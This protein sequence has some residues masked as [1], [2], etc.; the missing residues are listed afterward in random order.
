MKYRTHNCNELSLVHEGQIVKLAGW[1]HR[2][3]DHGGILFI[4]LRDKFGITQIVCSSKDAPELHKVMDSLRSEWVIAIEGRVRKR[5]EGMSNPNLSTGE[6]EVEV[7]GLT[8]LSKS[9]VPPFS[10]C[11]D[12]VNVNEELRL[13]YRYLDMRRGDILSKLSLRHQLMMA[14][15]KY[16]DKKG[17]TEVVTPVL[18]K[19]TPE[20]ARD[21]VVPSR[22]HPGDFYALPQSPQIFKQL[23]MIGGL[24]KYF[25]IATCFRDEDLRADRQPEFSQIDMEM[26]FATQEDLFLLVEGLVKEL[27]LAGGVEIHGALPRMT[28][29][30]AIDEYGTDKPD[31]RFGMKLKDCRAYANQFTFSIFL[32]QLA[33]GGT[34][35]GF[36]VEGGADISRKQID[37]YTEFVKRYGSQGLVWI[38]KINGEI[39][40]NV[41]KFASKEVFETLLS[42]LE[43]E[44]GDAAFLIA[45]S[46]KIVN[47]S[48]DHLRRL[49]AKER[50]LCDPGQYAFIWVTD[51]PLFAEEDGKIVSEH[52]PFT[53]PHE[54]DIEFLETDPLKVRSSGY[55]LVLNGYEIASGSQRIHCSD[56]QQQVFRVL[57]L[58]LE[59]IKNKFG[60]FTEALRFGTPPHLG[61]ALGLDRIV[62]ILGKAEGIREVIAFPKTQK[63]TDLMM[64]APSE[65]G[66]EQMKE[67][68][69]RVNPS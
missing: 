60:F 2:F 56:L 24:D 11:D 53:S 49:I 15:R 66:L 7:Q 37:G 22:V 63:A 34:V 36:R 32:D 67:L 18:C 16:M 23:L 6:I 10:I 8:V 27:F 69:I 4:D 64:Q 9:E 57:N 1:V 61:I 21:Y 42:F 3:R 25:Q 40:S 12:H 43:V 17:F 54:K 48:L 14:C 31:L 50:G 44:E 68:H 28:Y 26:S 62:M 41:L 30:Q 38:R 65:I 46:D 13:Q 5:L 33:S 29:Q 55:D 52:H 19:S 45:S 47:Q 39:S 59:D 20:G 51:F 35:K 58:S